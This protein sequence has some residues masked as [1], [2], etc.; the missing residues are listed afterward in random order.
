MLHTHGGVMRDYKAPFLMDEPSMPIIAIPT[1]SGTGSEATKVT[2][3]TDS[4]TDEK[5]LC[6]GVAYLPI[7]A[8]LDYELT[9]TKPF[10]LTAD[11]GIDAVCHAMEA[12]V[13]AKANP[14]ADGLALS[15]MEKL[16]GALYTACHQPSDAVARE[17]MLLGSCQAGMAFSNSS[18]TLI[19][20][21]SRPL[22]AR[23]HIPHGAACPAAPS[24]RQPCRRACATYAAV[25]DRRHVQ[26]NADANMYRLW[27]GRSGQAVRH[28]C[29]HAGAVR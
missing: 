19:H 5:M 24:C 25:P 27:R 6:V 22:G 10:R 12:F 13:S 26:R 3:I 2:I 11:T 29:T 28:G 4:A 15:A 17:A 16:G 18:V 23:F 20:G 1:T 8:I 14:F 9:L 7:A 21:M